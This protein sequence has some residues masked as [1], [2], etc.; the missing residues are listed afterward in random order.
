MSTRYGS[1]G[2]GSSNYGSGSSGSG[3]FG[4]GNFGSGSYGSARPKRKKER[5]WPMG[6]LAVVMTAIAGFMISGMYAAMVK[7]NGAE[8]PTVSIPVVVDH[9]PVTMQVPIS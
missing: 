5:H 9:P 1:S 8:E 7:L 6:L 3:N 2:Y 4:S